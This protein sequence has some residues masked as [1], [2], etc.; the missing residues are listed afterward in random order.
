MVAGSGDGEDELFTLND[1]GKAIW[2]QLDAQRS[3]AGVVAAI[4]TEFEGAEDGA[5]ERDP[6]GLVAELVQR[7]MLVA[8]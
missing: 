7:R 6:L 1:A 8:A 4:E 5:R 2:D 3:L